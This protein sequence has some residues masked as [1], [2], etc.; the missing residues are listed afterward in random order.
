M[1]DN[2]LQWR[3]AQLTEGLSYAP[4]ST[5][6]VSLGNRN[7]PGDSTPSGLL[8]SHKRLDSSKVPRVAQ[9]RTAILSAF[10]CLG[11][12]LGTGCTLDKRAASKSSFRAAIQNVLDRNPQ[13]IG[14]SLPE[15]IPIGN[16]MAKPTAQTRALLKIGFAIAKQAMIMPSVFGWAPARPGESARPGT[17][18]E[19]TDEAK[20]YQHK[21]PSFLGGEIPGLYYAKREVVDVL[22]FTEPVENTEAKT[23]LVTYT[24]RLRD[25]ARWIEGPTVESAFHVELKDPQ[26]PREA[27][28]KLLL[29]REGWRDRP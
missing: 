16:R 27:E 25:I 2:S 20:K 7:S 1:T 3:G 21:I 14:I 15:I 9:F 8:R 19:L 17:I 10:V 26:K 28:I 4:L 13:C 5:F 24:Y 11:I 6:C 18:Y 29:T 12:A 22:R 23:T